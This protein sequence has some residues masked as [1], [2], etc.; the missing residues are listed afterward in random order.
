MPRVR[1]FAP[2]ASLQAELADLLRVAKTADPAARTVTIGAAAVAGDSAPAPSVEWQHLITGA[3]WIAARH[4]PDGTARQRAS[5]AAEI[6][7]AAIRGEFPPDWWHPCTLFGRRYLYHLPDWTTPQQQP[8]APWNDP[9]HLSSRVGWQPWAGAY[10]EAQ[11]GTGPDAPG[12]GWTGATID[13][14]YRDTRH[15]VAECVFTLPPGVTKPDPPPL[16]AHAAAT[17]TASATP[18]GNRLW[19]SPTAYVRPYSSPTPPPPDPRRCL[20]SRHDQRYQG[21]IAAGTPPAWSDTRSHALRCPEWAESTHR[22]WY[23][24]TRAA[25][26]VGT[27]PALGAYHA[28]CDTIEVRAAV[29]AALYVGR[30][31]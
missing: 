15:D 17:I 10:A 5:L 19:F 21:P 16:L 30:A 28:R 29:T 26:Y 7:D 6:A 11:A 8:P 23:S 25:V 31:P 22:L 9:A 1:G 14:R 3:A 4:R 27:V 18:R 12:V 13:G 2:P 24:A 20:H